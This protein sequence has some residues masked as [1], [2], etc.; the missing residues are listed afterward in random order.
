MAENAYTSTIYEFLMA[1]LGKTDNM[2]APTQLLL[3][4]FIDSAVDQISREG[5]TLDLSKADD[6]I[7]VSMYA[8][9]LYRKRALSGDDSKMPRMLRYR[10]NNRLFAEKGAVFDDAA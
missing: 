7:T 3:R 9:Y 1:D 8:A 4:G 10:L 6:Q 2:P 5:I